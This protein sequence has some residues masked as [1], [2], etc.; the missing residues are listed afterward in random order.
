MKIIGILGS[1]VEGGMFSSFDFNDRKKHL[2]DFDVMVNYQPLKFSLKEQTT[3]FDYLTDVPGHLKIVITDLQKLKINNKYIETG[4]NDKNYL[5]AFKVK[6]EFKLSNYQRRNE[7]LKVNLDSNPMDGK[8]SISINIKVNITKLLTIFTRSIDIVNTILN[9]STK[10]NFKQRL[11]NKAW[12]EIISDRLFKIIHIH[13]DLVPATECESWPRIAGEWITRKRYWP[14]KTVIDQIIKNGFHVVPKCS[15]N[16]DPKFEW[17]ISFSKAELTLAEHRN[18]IQKKCYYIFKSM[19]KEYLGK[20]GVISTYYL[21]TIMMWAMEENPTEYWREDNIG[22]AVLGL[23]DDLYQAVH[24]GYLQNYF[25]KDQNLLRD[26]SK[27]ALAQAAKEIAVFRQ[28]VLYI[29]RQEKVLLTPKARNTPYEYLMSVSQKQFKLYYARV[30]DILFG[31]RTSC[32]Q[33]TVD[34]C[35]FNVI[36]STQAEQRSIWELDCL[37]YPMINYLEQFLTGQYNNHSPL[38]KQRIKEMKTQLRF[39]FIKSTKNFKDYY[40]KSK[41]KLERV[42]SKIRRNPKMFEELDFIAISVQ[43]CLKKLPITNFSIN[44]IQN[45]VNLAGK[46]HKQILQHYEEINKIFNVINT[47]WSNWEHFYTEI[48]KL[49]QNGNYKSL[50]QKYL[51]E[52]FDNS[53]HGELDICINRKFQKKPG[54]VVELLSIAHDH[55]E[56]ATVLLEEI[57]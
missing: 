50:I 23:L 54:E 30:V 42:W 48:V 25:I 17:R 12:Q 18:D 14:P 36:S 41:D 11:L 40:Y 20:S 38:I 22:Q 52:Y 19:F 27:D 55:L 57:I 9:I 2:F 4:N 35:L 3:S 47:K 5:S 7:D 46:A 51:K 34:T 56:K 13:I 8:A 49:T 1:S 43:S 28:R 21:K 45:C 29:K 32:M 31:I 26:K 37:L 10:G 6:N 53:I 15:T 33:K 39:T 16:G 44:E 24:L